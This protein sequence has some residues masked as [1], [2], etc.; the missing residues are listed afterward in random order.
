[1]YLYLSFVPDRKRV[2]VQPILIITH[3]AHISPRNNCDEISLS[4]ASDIHKLAVYSWATFG[5]KLECSTFAVFVP[6][7]ACNPNAVKRFKCVLTAGPLLDHNSLAIT[8]LVLIYLNS[9][10]FGLESPAVLYRKLIC[11]TVMDEKWIFN[12]THRPC[13][14]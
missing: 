10:T 9:I 3:L 8:K 7:L 11:S 1:M 6:F 12:T 5:P 2:M 13:I 4:L 14:K